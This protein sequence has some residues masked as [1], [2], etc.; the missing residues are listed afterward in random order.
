MNIKKIL[1]F[2]N[3][4]KFCRHSVFKLVGMLIV[5]SLISSYAVSQEQER[6]KRTNR[7]LEEVIV[8]AQKREEN[9]QDIPIAITAFSG[10]KLEALGIDSIQD[11]GAVTPGLTTSNSAGF[12]VVFLRGIG[13]DAF[14]PGADTSVP[15]YIDGVQ[16]ISAVQGTSDTLGRIDRIEVL[17]GPQGTL[18]GRNATGGAINIVTPAP[19]VEEWAGDITAEFA[20]YNEQ[21]FVGYV[22]GPIIDSVAISLS[23]YTKKHDNYYTN[24]VH[25][26]NLFDPI[27]AEGGRAKLLWGV[28]DTLDITLT[29]SVNKVQGNSGLNFE[30]TRPAPAL[31]AGGLV[32]PADPKADREVAHDAMAGGDTKMTLYSLIADW[33]LSHFDLKFIGSKQNSDSRAFADFDGSAMPVATADPPSQPSEQIT[34]ELQLVSNSDTPYSEHF[35][36]ATGIFYLEG[37]GGFDPVRFNFFPDPLNG[38]GLPL[39]APLSGLLDSVVDIL[40]LPLVS[41]S[42]VSLYNTGI[43]ESESLSAF[44][45]GTYYI[46]PDYLDVTVGMRYQ[47]EERDLA[48]SR[49]YTKNAN[50]DEITI[51][52][53]DLPVQTANQLSP[54]VAIKWY[55]FHTDDQVYAS[56]SRGFKSPTYNTVNIIVPP[57][58]VKEE[59]VDSFEVG[60]KASLFDDNLKLNSALFMIEQTDLLTGFVAIASGGIVQ[61]ANAKGSRVKGAELDVLWTP[62]PDLNPGFTIT[63]A[64]SHLDTEY[65][66]YKD[67]RGFDD[68]TGLAFGDGI[69]PLPS[70]DFTGNEIVRAPKNTGTLGFSQVLPLGPGD[71]EFGVN[72][73][74][75]S[76]F[77]F[78]AQNSDLYK[79]EEYTLVGAQITYFL[80]EYGLQATLF[81]Q[82]LTD[83]IYNESVFS[84]D[85][86]RAVMLNDPKVIGGRIKYSF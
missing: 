47:E 68:D 23:A 11:L 27:T 72:L 46:S 41:S 51:R 78:L 71:I 29:G 38:L 26:E 49:V 31:S 5:T 57:S 63:A 84:S 10:A 6:V 1:T 14:L 79:R 55:P 39:A 60:L 73:Q 21:N 13:T 61:Y 18:F 36:W 16:L 2:V 12:N 53:D 35:E 62:M 3:E 56:W 20:D 58:P 76:G 15:F 42:G 54:K 77:Y 25:P 65:T 85:F 34:Y 83:E 80:D 19:S 33:R 37:F 67:G 4:S 32:L 40:G 81:G 24:T 64:G 8:T 17:K 48:V 45:Q 9:L 30:L 59:Q 43:L 44:F 74:Y 82:N 70:R 66:D 50:G 7:L 86:G 22:S 28:T 75:S 69:T 52:N